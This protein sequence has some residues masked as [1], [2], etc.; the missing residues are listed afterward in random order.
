MAV[1]SDT[2]SK[3]TPTFSTTADLERMTSMSPDVVD[4]GFKMAATKPELEI[5]F[6][7]QVMAPRFQRLPH[8]VDHA[9][10]HY[11]TANIARRCLTTEIKNGG[12]Q[13]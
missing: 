6:E 5:T 10:L 9:R 8:I 7:R 1:D 3:A 13:T 11:V 4:Y 2:I 12:H